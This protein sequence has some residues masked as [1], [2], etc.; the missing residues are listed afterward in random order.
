MTSDTSQNSLQNLFRALEDIASVDA[1]RIARLL[2]HLHSK[3]ALQ[4]RDLY[5]LKLYFPAFYSQLMTQILKFDCTFTETSQIFE[6]ESV[7]RTSLQELLKAQGLRELFY[8]C[9][10]LFFASN[11]IDNA[12]VIAKHEVTPSIKNTSMDEMMLPE[13]LDNLSTPATHPTAEELIRSTLEFQQFQAELNALLPTADDL[14]VNKLTAASKPSEITY[15]TTSARALPTGKEASE[16]QDST[17][18]ELAAKET[19]FQSSIS[20]RERLRNVTVSRVSS[21]NTSQVTKSSIDTSLHQAVTSVLPK[22]DITFSHKFFSKTKN[23]PIENLPETEKAVEPVVLHSALNWTLTENLNFPTQDVQL[24]IRI[25]QSSLLH[26]T[27]SRSY[28]FFVKSNPEILATKQSAKIIE[29]AENSK[30]NIIICAR[31]YILLPK[32]T[33]L[34][35]EAWKIYTQ[36]KNKKLLLKEDGFYLLASDMQ[37]KSTIEAFQF[38]FGSF[39][40][41]NFQIWQTFSATTHSERVSDEQL[42]EMLNT[43][44]S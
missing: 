17:T 38:L 8:N 29:S 43:P 40:D 12:K 16:V 13:F 28:Q 10:K 2:S 7:E 33:Q 23:L 5:E 1:W 36:A 20:I 32:N 26:K 11:S 9:T 41:I 3:H 27:N 31:S 18:L 14:S 21:E 4:T 37:F 39:E 6:Y 25:A 42:H 22:D 44:L 34:T 30:T 24:R 15:N 35:N 19:Q